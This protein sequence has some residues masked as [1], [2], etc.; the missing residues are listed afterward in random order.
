MKFQKSNKK[1]RKRKAIGY[2]TTFT[3]RINIAPVLKPEHSDYL[4]R[5]CNTRR[6]KRDPDK[7]ILRPDSARLAVRLPIGVDGEFFVG[8]EEFMGQKHSGDV[9]DYNEEPS[10]QP[11]LWCCWEITN[12]NAGI[13]GPDQRSKFYDYVE[14]LKYMMENFFVPWGY[15]VN[16]IISWQ[17]EQDDDIGKIIAINS[18]I[19]VST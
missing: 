5:F 11:G 18:D 13:K 3:G 2:N 17:G 1:Q 14:W 19:V 6:M 12:D 8:E 10:T 15:T 4:K 16:G 7:T 9:I